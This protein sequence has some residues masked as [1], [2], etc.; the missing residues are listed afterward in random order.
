MRCVKERHVTIVAYDGVQSL[1]IVG[2]HEVFASAGQAAA[3]LGRAGRYRVTVASGRGGV[4]RTESG[5]EL[6]TVRLPGHGT[7]FWGDGSVA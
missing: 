3:S 6:G 2:P 1:D 4:V 7:P 5:L